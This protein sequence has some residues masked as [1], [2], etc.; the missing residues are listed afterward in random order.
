MERSA[1]LPPDAWHKALK[2]RNLRSAPT[3]Q[4]ARAGKRITMDD[5]WRYAAL[6]R[7]AKVMRPCMESLSS[8]CPIATGNSQLGIHHWHALALMLN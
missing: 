5:L 4:E 2:W 1:P 3:L 8:I 7:V 6:C